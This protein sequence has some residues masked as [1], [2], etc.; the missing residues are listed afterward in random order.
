MKKVVIAVEPNQTSAV[1]FGYSNPSGHANCVR[2]SALR[3]P[4][5]VSHSPSRKESGVNLIA[6]K[7]EPNCEVTI[8]VSDKT[9]ISS[10]G[11]VDAPALMELSSLQLT[12]APANRSSSIMI[13]LFFV[14][15]ILT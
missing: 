11:R 1:S 3:V 8:N 9:R 12:T 5:W 10:S 15:F 2:I 14:F 13:K 7:L 6:I 4:K